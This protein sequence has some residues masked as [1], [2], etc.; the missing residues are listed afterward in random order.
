MYTMPLIGE[1]V[2]LYFPN[3]SSEKPIITGC[4]RG[5]GDTCEQTSDT[6]S[7]YLQTEHGSEI[8]FLPNALNITG[9]SEEPLSVNFDDA[10]GVT[11]TS[12]K[13][14][15][16]NA[17]GSIIIQ[18]P[19]QV[20]INATSQLEVVKADTTSGISIEGDI[21]IKGNNVINNGSSRESYAPFPEGGV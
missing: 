8:A 1:S 7:R 17:F 21:H 2:R 9:G 3:E 14:L 11:L 13:E 16:L 20:N 15:S 19:K 10:T 12:P 6:S 5:N 18:T 4:V